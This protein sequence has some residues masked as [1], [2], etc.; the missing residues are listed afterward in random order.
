MGIGQ[1]EHNFEASIVNS[2]SLKWKDI[3]VCELG[4]MERKMEP[5]MP[6]KCY[7]TNYL[8]VKEHVSIDINGKWGSLQVDLD[9]PIPDE[10][11]NRFALVTNYGTGEHVNNQYSFF[12]NAHDLCKKEGIIIHALVPIGH[13]LNH[14]RYYYDENF[15]FNLANKCDYEILSL[16]RELKYSDRPD[17]ELI[18]VAYKKINDRS[19]IGKN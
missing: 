9:K 11:K 3:A 2:Q 8:G 16:S 12:K 10:L 4:N 15:V 6:A 19:F 14:C 5:E 7:Y 1:L 17:T 13:W 18:M